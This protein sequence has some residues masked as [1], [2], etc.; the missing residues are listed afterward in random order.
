MIKKEYYKMWIFMALIALE[1]LAA[2]L[3][4]PITPTI[5]KNLNL[6]SYMFGLA[7]AGMAFTNFLFSPFWGKMIDRI[8]SRKVLLITSLGYAF[9]Q[10]LFM[11]GKDSIT[12][13]IARLVSGLFAGGIFVSF[14]TYIVKKCD[15]DMQGKFLAINATLQ[16]VFGAFGY[17]VGGYLGVVSIKL[18]FIIQVS[19]LSLC[20][21]LFFILSDTEEVIK[22]EKS[23]LKEVNPFKSF[24]ESKYFMNKM[25][26]ILFFIV[27]LTSIATTCYDQNFNY[28]IKDVLGLTSNYNGIFKAT[29]G[30]ITLI[31]NSTICMYILKKNKGKKSL[32]Y[33]FLAAF[34]VLELMFYEKNIIPFLVINI[35]YFAINAMYIPLLQDVVAKAANKNQSS[36]IMGFYNAMMSCGKVFGALVAGFIYANG[37][38]LPF[39]IAGILFFL[40]SMLMY[41]WNKKY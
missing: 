14:L 12:I 20:G 10:L 32:I 15:K 30:V 28:Y 37:A 6:P 38:A 40:A 23:I 31:V 22:S 34:V 1:C 24:M 27:L 9:G 36:M 18:T 11:L 25:F 33:I 26:A 29:V 4:H 39:M 16:S 17:L 19:L 35:L 2:N 8:S 21:I 13:M 7:F 5:I 3:A 41:W